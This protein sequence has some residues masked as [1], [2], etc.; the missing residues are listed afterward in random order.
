MLKFY[1][2]FPPVLTPFEIH[3]DYDCF[4]LVFIITLSS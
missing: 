4:L 3:S 2:F 1:N